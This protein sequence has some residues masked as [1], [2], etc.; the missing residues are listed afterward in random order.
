MAERFAGLAKVFMVMILYM[1][2]YEVVLYEGG[3]LIRPCHLGRVVKTERYGGGTFHS[4]RVE[5]SQLALDWWPM[6]QKYAVKRQTR[7][8]QLERERGRRERRSSCT[9]GAALG[10]RKESGFG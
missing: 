7:S 10:R 9:E 3:L 4:P 8:D 5:R 6:I 2:L 1:I